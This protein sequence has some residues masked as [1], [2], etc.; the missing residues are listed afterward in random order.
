MKI[1]KFMFPLI[2]IMLVP[3]CS[4][5]VKA[6]VFNLDQMKDESTILLQTDSIIRDGATNKA[7]VY[8]YSVDSLRYDENRITYFEGPITAE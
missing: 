3:S 2:C 7:V 1:G 8:R 5:I 4:T 6:T